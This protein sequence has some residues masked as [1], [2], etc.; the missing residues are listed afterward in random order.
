MG[1]MA[2]HQTE[3]KYTHGNAFDALHAN[4]LLGPDLFVTADRAFYAVLNRVRE[5]LDRPANVLLM[6]RS[7]ES[8]LAELRRV[9]DGT[10]A[11]E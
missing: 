11:H 8:A 2:Y 3:A 5:F 6:E 1:I 9:I 7:A 10:L 4:Y